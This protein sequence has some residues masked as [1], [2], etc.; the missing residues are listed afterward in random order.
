VLTFSGV[1][2]EGIPWW[3][4]FDPVSRMPVLGESGDES[5]GSTI[6]EFFID[7]FT[8]RHSFSALEFPLCQSTEV[9]FYDEALIPLGEYGFLMM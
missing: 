5:E 8:P 6:V 1:D 7:K 3:S 9:E 4:Y 2:S